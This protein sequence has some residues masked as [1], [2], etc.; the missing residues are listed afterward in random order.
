LVAGRHG[1]LPLDD[2]RGGALFKSAQPRGNT[3]RRNSFTF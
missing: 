1:V 2:R 3:A